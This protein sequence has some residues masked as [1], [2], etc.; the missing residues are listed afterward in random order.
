MD[1]STLPPE[2]QFKYLLGLHPKE[3]LSY[4]R[5]STSA[6]AIC[7][8]PYFWDQKS[9]QDFGAPFSA[10]CEMSPYWKYQFMRDMQWYPA[11]IGPLVRAGR[12]DL[13]QEIYRIE[14]DNNPELVE[15]AIVSDDTA[16]LEFLRPHIAK[17]RAAPHGVYY[18]SDPFFSWLLTAFINNSDQSLKFLLSIEPDYLEDL[19]ILEE[20]LEALVEYEN[21]RGIN[22][23]APYIEKMRREILQMTEDFPELHDYLEG[24]M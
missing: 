9:I 4:C 10:I 8:D 2:V 20:T 23:L 13:A 22:M 17:M 12:K 18:Q 16:T 24:E 1:F 6:R 11:M 19:V 5:A 15:G 3:I 21:Q 7:D 14:G